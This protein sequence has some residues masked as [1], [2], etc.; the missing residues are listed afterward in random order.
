MLE[1][2]AE[3]EKNVY[4]FLTVLV[5][6][7]IP[8]RSIDILIYTPEELERISH[9]SFIKT[10]FREGKVIYEHREERTGSLEVDSD[11]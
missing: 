10:I 5:Y 2:I 11:R 1:V 3:L 4:I 6:E 7:I 8:D 9:R